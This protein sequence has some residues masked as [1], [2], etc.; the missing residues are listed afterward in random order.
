M[1]ENAKQVL[2]AVKNDEPYPD[3]L[4]D[5]DAWLAQIDLLRSGDLYYDESGELRAR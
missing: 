4:D 2:E 1:S 5:F 3:D